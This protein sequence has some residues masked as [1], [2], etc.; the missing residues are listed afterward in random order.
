MRIRWWLRIVGSLY[1]L[2]GGLN[3][4]LIVV[5]P[6]ILGDNLP[7]PAND[8]V[9]KAFSDAWLVFAL[10]LIALG[11][12]MLYASRTP[13]GNRVLVLTVIMIEVF[14]GVVADAIWIARGHS[15]LIYIPFIAAH[16]VIIGTGIAFLR[17]EPTEQ[18]H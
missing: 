17:Q 14:S 3:L 9:I 11:L 4:S 10:G 12:T 2:A 7:Y 16:L 15:P 5:Q 13:V 8:V 6:K 1:L 18:T